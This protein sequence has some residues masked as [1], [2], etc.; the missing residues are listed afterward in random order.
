[1]FVGAKEECRDRDTAYEILPQCKS[2]LIDCF[3]SPLCAFRC[4]HVPSNALRLLQS[5]FCPCGL[6]P[7]V[8]VQPDQGPSDFCKQKAGSSKNVLG[9]ACLSNV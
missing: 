3:S 9:E 4:L 8:E 7:A 5:V 2:T 1:M 6:G